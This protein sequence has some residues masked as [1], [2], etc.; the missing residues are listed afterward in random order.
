M[1]L[2][3]S[4]LRAVTDVDV[5]SRCW[6]ALGAI[7]LERSLLGAPGSPGGACR[8]FVVAGR[9]DGAAASAALR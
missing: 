8:G 9:A 7:G 3:S 2:M 5:A 1:V 6:V 4:N